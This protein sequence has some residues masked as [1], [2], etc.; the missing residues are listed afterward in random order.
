[1]VGRG[2]RDGACVCVYTGVI[3]FRMGVERRGMLEADTKREREN[4]T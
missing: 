1:M 4:D 3:D 2:G